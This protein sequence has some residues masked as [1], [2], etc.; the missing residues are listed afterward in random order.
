MF[1]ISVDIHVLLCLCPFF[2]VFCVCGLVDAHTNVFDTVDV[3][4]NEHILVFLRTHVNEHMNVDVA[5]EHLTLMF[6]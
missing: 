4:V 2:Y 1:Q 3:H 6:L 5:V